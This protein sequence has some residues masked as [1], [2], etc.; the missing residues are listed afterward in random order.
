M[1]NWLGQR[2]GGGG[3]RVGEGWKKWNK[4]I[5]LRFKEKKIY[6]CSVS[7]NLETFMEILKKGTKY[8]GIYTV[9]C[10]ADERSNC[11]MLVHASD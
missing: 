9:V 3:Q 1:I 10:I 8:T 4:R 6:I 11:V 2:W 7:E 5:Y